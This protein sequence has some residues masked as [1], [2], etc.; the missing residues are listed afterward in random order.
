MD[1]ADRLDKRK[2]TVCRRTRTGARVTRDQYL[3]SARA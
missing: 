1:I 2:H 3:Y